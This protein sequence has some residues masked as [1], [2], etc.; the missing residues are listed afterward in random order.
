MAAN[1][2]TAH[3]H[4]TGESYGQHFG[5]AFGVSRQLAGAAFAALVHAVVPSLHKST[6]SEKI[7]ALNTCLERHDR[8]GLRKNA[9]LRVVDGAA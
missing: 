2:F 9:E 1:P 3:P 5:V 4:A 8:D 7:K 6:A